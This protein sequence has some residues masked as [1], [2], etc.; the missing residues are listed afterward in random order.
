MKCSVNSSLHKCERFGQWRQIG[1]A[2]PTYLAG[3]SAQKRLFNPSFL[4]LGPNSLPPVRKKLKFPH[5]IEFIGLL[6]KR[7]S[8]AWSFFEN[9]IQIGRLTVIAADGRQRHFGEAV[10]LPQL[11][12]Q[13]PGALAQF[14]ATLR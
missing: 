4:A 7:R 12:S 10:P 1:Y 9:F 5:L 8:H 11:N 13:T 14:F 6:S 2:S 3:V